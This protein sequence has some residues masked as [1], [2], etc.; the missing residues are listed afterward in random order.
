MQDYSDKLLSIHVCVS[1]TSP[2][3]SQ[4]LLWLGLELVQGII[5]PHFIFIFV[6]FPSYI[7]FAV[8]WLI[9]RWLRMIH[10]CDNIHLHA[11]CK[12]ECAHIR[13][14]VKGYFSLLVLLRE[15]CRSL[16]LLEKR[17]LSTKQTCQV[18]LKDL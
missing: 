2:S 13:Y 16:G 12:H 11:I 1:Y 9:L 14:D 15:S 6:T 3:L 18:T 10:R 8:K 17:I 7:I 4:N 5:H